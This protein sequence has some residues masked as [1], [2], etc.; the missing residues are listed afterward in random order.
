MF[1]LIR[2]LIRN[3]RISESSNKILHEPALGVLPEQSREVEHDA[4]DEEEEDDP[5]VI[6]VIGQTLAWPGGSDPWV[7]LLYSLIMKIDILM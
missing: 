5:L 1:L 3:Q 6:F 4:L 2:Y 7:R